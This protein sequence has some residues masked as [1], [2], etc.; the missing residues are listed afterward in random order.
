MSSTTHSVGELPVDGL[1]EI[2]HVLAYNGDERTWTQLAFLACNDKHLR[3]MAR[4][5]ERPLV[6]EIAFKQQNLEDDYVPMVIT[7]PFVQAEIINVEID[8]GDGS[9]REAYNGDNY[10]RSATYEYVAGGS[11]TVRV[12]PGRAQPNASHQEGKSAVYL[13][14]L[15]HSNDD[16]NDDWWKPLRA[17]KTLGSLGITSLSHLFYASQWNFPLEWLNVSNVTNMSHM[18]DWAIK[19]DQPIER[20]NVGN[21]VNMPTC[22]TELHLSISP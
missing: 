10:L 20:W 21:V 17:I 7:I 14:H 2:L 9:E 3:T 15:G 19:F 6:L 5:M 8:G 18:I 1:C 16:K 13:D 12:F 22:L 4:S 11:Y